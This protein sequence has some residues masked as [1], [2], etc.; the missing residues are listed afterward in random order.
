[1]KTRFPQ[2]NELKFMA[3]KSRGP[4]GQN[5]NKVSSAALLNWHY[6]DSP[7]FN[8]E[9]KNLITLKLSNHI[10]KENVFYI[11]SDEF[12][13]LERNKARCLE[14]LELLL[15]K[16]LHKPKAR[17]KT[18]PTKSSQVKRV[19]SKKQRGQVKQSRQKVKY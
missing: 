1:M 2:S 14:K 4:G 7:Q 19:D 12:R 11:R 10:N 9:E 16:A 3:S 5:V 17:R 18:K 8:D 15:A 6:L 13:D